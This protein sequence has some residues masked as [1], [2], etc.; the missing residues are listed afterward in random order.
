[1]EN[2]SQEGIW[3]VFNSDDPRAIRGLE[4]ACETVI[5]IDGYEPEEALQFSAIKRSCHR[6]LRELKKA[7]VS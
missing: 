1:M 3:Y 4:V 6:I 5:N 2:I 7:V